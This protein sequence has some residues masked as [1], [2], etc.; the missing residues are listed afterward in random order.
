M[1]RKKLPADIKLDVPLIRAITALR[2]TLDSQLLSNP[3]MPTELI[4]LDDALERME[5]WWFEKQH[6]LML[7]TMVKYHES[8]FTL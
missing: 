3:Q 8:D 6:P 2:V 1:P 4:E 7:T 5:D